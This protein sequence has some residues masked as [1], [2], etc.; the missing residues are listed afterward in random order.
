MENFGKTFERPEMKQ[1]ETAMSKFWEG[2]EKKAEEHG[3][4]TENERKVDELTNYLKNPHDNERPDW[5]ADRSEIERRIHSLP[6]G[7]D[8]DPKYNPNLNSDNR[9]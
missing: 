5:M 4:P 6:P 9:K 7:F 1:P 2:I 3:K 8:R